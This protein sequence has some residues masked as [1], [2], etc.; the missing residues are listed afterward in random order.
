M[1]RFLRCANAQVVCVISTRLRRRT[2]A[3]GFKPSTLVQVDTLRTEN[4]DLRRQLEVE[5]ASVSLL[6]L[7]LEET[8]ASAPSPSASHVALQRPE[9]SIS[10]TISSQPKAIPALLI[11]HMGRLVQDSSGVERFA[12]TTTGVHFM[13]LV[14]QAVR[15][16][17][18]FGD[19]PES[20]FKMYLLD[21]VNHRPFLIQL[22]PP[23]IIRPTL[24]ELF[25][26][27]LS[28]YMDQVVFFANIWSC[29]CPIIEPTDLVPRLPEAINQAQ[30][31]TWPFLGD[32]DLVLFQLALV[33]MINSTMVSNEQPN[34]VSAQEL[35]SYHDAVAATLPNLLSRADM[36]GLHGIALLSFYILLVGQHQ[37]MPRINGILVQYAFSLG[38]HRHSRRFKYDQKENE[39]RK[40]LWWW[41]YIFDKITAIS[42]GL[43]MLIRDNDIDIDYP[44]DCDLSNNGESPHI[45]LPLPGESTP[46]NDF[47]AFVHLSRILSTTLDQLYTT[48][49]RR[50]GPDKIVKLRSELLGWNQ[51][52]VDQLGGQIDGNGL[53]R[54]DIHLHSSPHDETPSRLLLPS[55]S[56]MTAMLIHR[57]G[58]TFADTTPEFYES[59]RWCAASSSMIIENASIIAS[60]PRMCR[61][62]FPP[63]PNIIFQSAMLHIFLWCQRPADSDFFGITRS[64]S[65]D[66]INQTVDIFSKRPFMNSLE[67]AWHWRTPEYSSCALYECLDLLQSLSNLVLCSTSITSDDGPFI[68]SSWDTQTQD[69]APEMSSQDFGTSDVALFDLNHLDYLDPLLED[70]VAQ[71]STPI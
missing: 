5:R 69:I 43:P 67:D 12:G 70:S 9:L 38:L 24:A 19:F 3:R 61:I 62:V 26:H 21:W 41:I 15:R 33:V 45:S 53:L 6:R 54:A 34:T 71:M 40:R 50:N 46:M 68:S 17:Q 1:G 52:F 55:V 37:S 32:Q 31:M 64:L 51:R 7:R 39:T 63:S 47:I 14:Q 42:H 58:L 66:R 56:N 44:L 18:L 8:V 57:P 11:K 20:S 29:L 16:K 23:T 30:H 60:D 4:A 65:L 27:P 59:L 36:I 48:T 49:S 2:T 13:L 35:S 22:G 10:H 25:R 28:Y